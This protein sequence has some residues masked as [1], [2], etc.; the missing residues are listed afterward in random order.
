MKRIKKFISVIVAMAMALT[1]AL[2]VMASGVQPTKK[3]NIQLP[4]GILEGHTYSAYQIFTGIEDPD[5]DNVLGDVQWGDGINSQ[6]FIEALKGSKTLGSKFSEINSEDPLSALAVANVLGSGLSEA[7]KNEVAQIAYKNK[8]GLGKALQQGEN[9]LASGYYLIVDATGEGEDVYNAALLQATSNVQIQ[10]KTDKPEVTKKIVSGDQL[11]DY[12]DAAMGGTVTYKISSNVPDMTQYKNYKFK[13]VDTLSKGLT[14]NS[15][16]VVKVNGA[17][18]SKEETSDN[19][20]GYVE[21]LT[22]NE[23]GTTTINILFKNFKTSYEKGDLIEVFYTATLNKDA[24]VGVSGNENKVKLEYSANPNE[25]GEGDE[26]GDGDVKGET[27]EDVVITYVT[28]VKILKYD[29]AD[30]TKNKVLKGAQFSITGEKLIQGLVTGTVFEKVETGKG[31]Y[32]KLKDNGGYTTTAPT[33][34]TK[35]KYETTTKD[36]NKVEKK[37]LVNLKAESVNFVAEVGEDGILSITGLSAGT[38]TIQEIKAP[39]GYNLLRDPIILVITCTTDVNDAE[40]GT[41]CTWSATKN[42]EILSSFDE[43]TGLFGLDVPNNQ[44]AQLPETGGIGTTIFYIV[45]SILVVGAAILLVT[46]KRMS[47]EV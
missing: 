2:P 1:M 15:D 34:D 22:N 11:V 36:Y 38:Y 33:D 41:K 44:G 8:A 32:Y 9:S 17:I 46:K 10:I 28:G 3:I 18:I 14:Y 21:E 40:S 43:A 13:I 12:N 29:G 37:D 35:N 19:K 42:G 4:G 31:A 23:N 30:D 7:E 26:F 47:K 27:P 6:T 5:N 45:G 39:D 24:I 25:V 20:G 16:L